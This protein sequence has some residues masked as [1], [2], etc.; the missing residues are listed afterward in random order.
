MISVSICKKKTKVW[1]WKKFRGFWKSLW[2]EGKWGIESGFCFY[3][4]I[5]VTQDPIINQKV[6]KNSGKSIQSI[7]PTPYINKKTSTRTKH[8]QNNTNI[9]GWWIL[10]NNILLQQRS[11]SVQNT[12]IV[13]PT[14]QKSTTSAKS[15][16]NGNITTQCTKVNT[17]NLNEKRVG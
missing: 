15:Q 2:Q 8:F 4:N 3:K 17:N 16:N 5:L 12:R 13:S 6:L 7:A 10:G 11:E 1:F 9:E 14:P